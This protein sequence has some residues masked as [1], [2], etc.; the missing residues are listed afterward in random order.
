MPADPYKRGKCR[1]YNELANS[2]QSFQ[3]CSLLACISKAELVFP[4]RAWLG[5]QKRSEKEEGN[6]REKLRKQSYRSGEESRGSSCWF[7]LKRCFRAGLPMREYAQASGLFTPTLSRDFVV[8]QSCPVVL[9]RY[10]PLLFFLPWPIPPP[11]SCSP[12]VAATSASV[13]E[14]RVFLATHC[15]V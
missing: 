13:P 4:W 9:P 7:L 8:R 12:L 14:N 3:S 15:S 2:Q 6:G 1:H 5:L 11:F 10:A